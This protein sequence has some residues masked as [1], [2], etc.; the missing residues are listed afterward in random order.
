MGAKSGIFTLMDIKMTASVY[1]KETWCKNVPRY[2][3][4]IAWTIHIKMRGIYHQATCGHI[5]LFACSF[6]FSYSYYIHI[7]I[8]ILY[9]YFYFR[10]WSPQVRSRK[11]TSQYSGV[12]A[13]RICKLCTDGDGAIHYDRLLVVAASIRH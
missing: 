8:F 5:L 7:F 4:F 1:V 13:I 3:S 2:G 10:Y 6:I 11:S 9:S 12:T